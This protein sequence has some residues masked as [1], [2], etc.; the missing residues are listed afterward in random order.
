[1]LWQLLTEFSRVCVI[2]GLSRCTRITVYE[3]MR[4]TAATE[5]VCVCVCVC[6]VCHVSHMCTIYPYT[7]LFILNHTAQIIVGYFVSD[8]VNWADCEGSE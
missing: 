7:K 4:E 1:M 2:T 6:G 8:E 5:T 3:L